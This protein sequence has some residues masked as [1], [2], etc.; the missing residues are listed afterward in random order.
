[1]RQIKALKMEVYKP[2]FQSTELVLKS[3]LDFN[4]GHYEPRVTKM[5]ID[6]NLCHK[7]QLHAKILVVR[8][9]WVIS[10]HR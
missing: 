10:P 3:F 5:R 1:M 9:M 2:H 6:L 7:V 4:L 8:K